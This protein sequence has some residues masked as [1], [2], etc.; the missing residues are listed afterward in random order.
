MLPQGHT[1]AEV[2]EAWEAFAETIV[3]S[4][5]GTVRNAFELG[6]RLAI[7]AVNKRGAK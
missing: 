7:E 5:L 4:L 6:V 3:A 1:Q 2:D